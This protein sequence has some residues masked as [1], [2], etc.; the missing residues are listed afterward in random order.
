MPVNFL[1]PS[2]RSSYG[3]YTGTPSPEELQRYF[4]LSDSD[5]E[6]VAEKRL[7][8]NRLGFALQLTTARFLG[9]FLENPIDVP[10]SVVRILCAQLGIQDLGC[11]SAYQDNRQHFA[12]RAEIRSQFGYRDFSDPDV[13][14]R[15]TRWLYAQCWTGTERPG[16]LFDRAISWLL[17]NKVLLPGV[18]VLE[19][20]VSRLRQRVDMRV[21]RLLGDSVSAEQKERLEALL[22]VPEGSRSSVLDQLRSGPVMVSVPALLCAVERLQKVRAVGITSSAASLIPPSR[23]ASLARVANTAKVT[24]VAN[25]PPARCLATLV[26]FVHTLEASASTTRSKSSRCSRM[27]CSPRRRKPTRRHGCAR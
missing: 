14:L 13:G 25:L 27:R 20:F 6:L 15:L 16:A 24:A 23:I 2:Q 10:P 3:R 8:H 18:S 17:A 4:H 11:V 12:H 5:R 1:T 19:R 21:C 9:T 22:L 7:D 26:A